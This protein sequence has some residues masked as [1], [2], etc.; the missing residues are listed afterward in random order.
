MIVRFTISSLCSL[1][2]CLC[3][4]FCDFIV[5]PFPYPST[6]PVILPRKL[7]YDT[8]YCS[9]S[10]ILILAYLL[11]LA[12]ITSGLIKNTRGI[13]FD[14]CLDYLPKKTT[15]EQLSWDSLLY[16]GPT[17]LY[18]YLVEFSLILSLSEI[19]YELV[20]HHVIEF[21]TFFLKTYLQTFLNFVYRC[22]LLLPKWSPHIQV[23][24][25]WFLNLD[26]C[27]MY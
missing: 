15:T 13:S 16:C 14:T 6:R 24:F 25:V 20:A 3:V 4:C 18:F 5:T 2:L 12:V 1:L 8:F 17:I 27:K 19:L 7:N 9:L 22:K 26:M 10:Q 11:A 23:V 21:L